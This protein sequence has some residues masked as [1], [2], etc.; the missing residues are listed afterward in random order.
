MV[1]VN[2]TRCRLLYKF[3]CQCMKASTL[4]LRTFK[5]IDLHNE[6]ELNVYP[7]CTHSIENKSILC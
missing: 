4:I 6:F 3:S 1:I 7:L 5:T 2:S